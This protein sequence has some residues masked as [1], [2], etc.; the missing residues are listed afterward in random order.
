MVSKVGL[1]VGCYRFTDNHGNATMTRMVCFHSALTT[2]EG[3]RVTQ[4]QLE[5]FGTRWIP[6]TISDKDR[7]AD[8]QSDLAPVVEQPATPRQ[9]LKL[10]ARFGP[11]VIIGQNNAVDKGSGANWATGA[12][13]VE[14][15]RSATPASDDEIPPL[16]ELDTPSLTETPGLALYVGTQFNTQFNRKT[17]SWLLTNPYPGPVKKGTPQLERLTIVKKHQVTELTKAIKYPHAD[18]VDWNRQDWIR[19]VNIWARQKYRRNDDNGRVESYKDRRRFLQIE[20]EWLVAYVHLQPVKRGFD[21]FNKHPH[22]NEVTDVF[23]KEFEGRQIEVDGEFTEPRS[24]RKPLSISSEC[25]RNADIQQLRGLRKKALK[26][27]RNEDIEG[28]K[29]CEQSYKTRST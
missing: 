27:T 12:E 20:R 6:G 19:K 7:R 11:T 3:T 25:N 28:E 23:N 18:N 21:T 9:A 1:V 14:G 22:W 13:A 24:A 16:G 5:E 26:R 15:S 4:Q 17:S 2:P 10:K 8:G 29:T